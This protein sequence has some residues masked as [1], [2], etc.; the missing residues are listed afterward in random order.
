M[1][2]LEKFAIDFLR[3]AGMRCRLDLPIS[4]PDWE[5]TAEIRHNLFLAFKEAVN[6]AAK[7][8]QG[9]AVTITLQLQSNGFTVVVSD[10]GRGLG[11]GETPG[12][13][14]AGGRLAGG[15][16]MANM[17]RRMEKIGGSFEVHSEAGKGTRVELSLP[18]VSAVPGAMS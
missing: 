11:A 14:P 13:E 4:L 1:S 7:H 16:G 3:T 6:N 8:S 15:D 18:V 9:T 17:R 5:L 2:Y 10:D 12:L